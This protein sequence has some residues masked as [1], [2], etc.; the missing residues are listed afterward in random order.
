MPYFYLCKSIHRKTK[1]LYFSSYKDL[2]KLMPE[3]SDVIMKCTLSDTAFQGTCE[4]SME[5]LRKVDQE[6]ES[7]KKSLLSTG[8]TS[9]GRNAGCT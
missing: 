3:V 2:H 6:S 1:T 7:L 8:N 4:T 5:E 9:R